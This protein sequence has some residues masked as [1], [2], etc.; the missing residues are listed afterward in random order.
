MTDPFE[1]VI[2][3]VIFKCPL[4][5]S[6]LP[7][8]LKQASQGSIYVTPKPDTSLKK[9]FLDET[10]GFQSKNVEYSI[11]VTYRLSNQTFKHL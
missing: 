3:G 10:S 7:D 4:Q 1:S 11:D 2:Y 9:Q 6:V 5:K 8:H